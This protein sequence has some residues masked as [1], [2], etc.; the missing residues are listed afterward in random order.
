[1]SNDPLA[2]SPVLAKELGANAFAINLTDPAR[3]STPAISEGEV[4]A[5]REACA[6]NGFSTAQILP[7]AAFVINLCSPDS[8]KLMLSRKALAD[9]MRRAHLLGL[10]MVN[11]HPG[12]HIK[13][14]SEGDALALVSESINIILSKTE[15]VTAVI[16][17]TAGQGSN[18]GYTFG[19]IGQIINGVDDKT[20]VGVCVDSAHAFAAGYDLATPEGYDA[21]WEEFAREVGF[22]YLRGMHLNDSQREVASRIDRHESIGQGKIGEPFFR[23]LMADNR[24]DNIPLI[25]ETPNPDIWQQEVALLRKFELEN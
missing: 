18:V 21:C 16:E 1:M 23:R 19:Q 15:G 17:N 5:F 13:Q 10:T 25:L 24:F 9:E 4:A 7:H 22:E 3:W 20:R 11:F 6:L 14:H 12:A 2:L 8:R